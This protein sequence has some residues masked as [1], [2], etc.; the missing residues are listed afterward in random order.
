MERHDQESFVNVTN[1]NL[2]S[3]ERNGPGYDKIYYTWHDSNND[4]TW[5]LN[6]RAGSVPD[7]QELTIVKTPD[8]RSGGNWSCEC[9][10]WMSLAACQFG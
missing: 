6:S 9:V 10:F 2:G 3:E 1:A 4:G 7:L 5:M 8:S